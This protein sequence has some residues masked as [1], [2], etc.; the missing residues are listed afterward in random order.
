VPTKFQAAYRRALKELA[1]PA[2]RG[3][4]QADAAPPTSRRRSAG[5]FSEALETVVRDV[6]ETLGTS[7]PVYLLSP[8][9]DR[10]FVATS[11]NRDVVG[12]LSLKLG[13]DWSRWSPG[14]EPINRRTRLTRASTTCRRSA[15]SHSTH[16]SACPSSTSARCS[17]C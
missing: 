6:R 17:G 13:W 1:P 7:L 10:L 14:A 16:S 2:G 15:K 3:T 12:K 9:R 5:S 11:L 8:E 4:P